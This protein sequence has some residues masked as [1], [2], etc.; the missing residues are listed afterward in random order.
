[1]PCLRFLGEFRSLLPYRA[2]A[3]RVVANAEMDRHH[4]FPRSLYPHLFAFAQP[5]NVL[6]A[7]LLAELRENRLECRL[8]PG[9][10]DILYDLHP[11][12]AQMG[13][14]VLFILV[15][16]SAIGLHRFFGSFEEMALILLRKTIP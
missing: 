5:P 8:K 7:E 14:A 11:L 10:V 6:L 2:S 3:P 13:H 1:P 15:D 4:P 16:A 9:A 12:G